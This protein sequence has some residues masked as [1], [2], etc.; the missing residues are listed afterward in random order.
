MHCE[1]I[2][3]NLQ[4][5][6][7]VL[8]LWLHEQLKD[9]HQAKSLYPKENFSIDH[10]I[11]QWVY[12]SNCLEKN[13]TINKK[14][15]KEK[16]ELINGLSFGK[17]IER[18]PTSNATVPFVTYLQKKIFFVAFIHLF[19][20]NTWIE[21]ESTNHF[22]HFPNHEYSTELLPVKKVQ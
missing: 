3:R 20:I 2:L 4:I 5:Y 15:K 6:S 10:S 7:V 8:R 12:M 9:Q 18:T 21:K 1:Q 22:Y 16:F 19:S 11:Q 13:K 17:I 14:K